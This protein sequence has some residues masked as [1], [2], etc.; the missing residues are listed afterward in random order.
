VQGRPMVRRRIYNSLPQRCSYGFFGKQ[1]AVIERVFCR[2]RTA[3]HMSELF[4]TTLLPLSTHSEW[5]SR[6][7]VSHINLHFST[8][9]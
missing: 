5:L 8:K 4:R 1:S 6:Q 2:R 9:K 3:A 7:P